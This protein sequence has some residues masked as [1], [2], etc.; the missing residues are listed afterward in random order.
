MT[1]DPATELRSEPPSELAAA[2]A[3]TVPATTTNFD[4]VFS[5]FAPYVLRILPRLGVRSAD[6]DDVTQD[7][8]LVVHR[9]LPKFEGRSSVKTWVYGI[10]IRVAHNYRDRAFRRHEQLTAAANDA[11]ADEQLERRQ[12]RDRD[13]RTP[14]RELA[15]KRALAHLDSA[16][17]KLPDAQ[18][19]T[20][21]LHEIEQL[22]IVEVAEALG[23]SKFTAYAR[24]Y[25]AK[26]R[27]L[28]EFPAAEFWEGEHD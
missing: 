25:A 28:V 26:R 5:E 10:C 22:T 20:F 18:R 14:L 2:R 17:Q 12:H 27:V 24:L 13:P 4:R 7:V 15:T 9:S 6:V 23:C 19:E 8:F 11:D 16:L 1:A 3:V 21:V